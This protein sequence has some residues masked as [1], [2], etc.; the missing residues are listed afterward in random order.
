[1]STLASLSFFQRQSDYDNYVKF[2]DT[3]DDAISDEHCVHDEH[4]DNHDFEDDDHVNNNDIY[5]RECNA[6]VCA[7]L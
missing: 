7:S 2:V 6:R 4:L 1:M 3:N 5:A